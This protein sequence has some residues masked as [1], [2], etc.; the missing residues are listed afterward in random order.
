[1]EQFLEGYIGRMRPVFA[2]IPES[3]AHELASAFL[4]FK[5]GLYLNVVRECDN[6]LAHIPDGVANG[7]LKKALL[8]VRANAQDLGN[9]QVTA[10]L[11]QAFSPEERQFVAIDIPA[12]K[13]EDPA[14][15]GLNNALILVYVVSL[16][17]SPD[18]EQALDEH[19]KFIVLLLSGY[20]KALGL[21]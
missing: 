5:F 8:I 17:R 3:T 14:T 18:D 1:M 4:A 20:K 13:N 11:S 19:R 9:S 2:A 12:E 6:A 21:E 15:L 16:I 10:D 7:A